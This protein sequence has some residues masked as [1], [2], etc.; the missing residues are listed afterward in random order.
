MRHFGKDKIFKTPY[1]KMRSSYYLENIV[2]L[3]RE[4]DTLGC[5]EFLKRKGLLRERMSCLFCETWM[6][7]VRYARMCDGF[8]WKCMTKSCTH[9]KTTL[10]IRTGSPFRDVRTSLKDLTFLIYLWATETPEKKACAEAGLSRPTVVQAYR[11]LRKICGTY[12]AA[13]P[14]RLGGPGITCQVDES[15]FCY[16]PKYHR[17]RAPEY[18]RW[19]FGVVDTS[20]TPACGYMECVERRDAATLLP[21]IERVCFP[22]TT[23]VSDGWAAYSGVQG[24]GYEHRV[25]NHSLHFVD[26]HT[27]AHTQHIESYWCR[28][29]GKLKAMKGIQRE[30]LDGYLHEFMWRE[31]FGGNAFENIL[32]H[33][34]LCHDNEP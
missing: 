29:K 8:R 23:V 24:L 15:L 6:V 34:K 12:L 21:I 9:Y 26:S 25:V 17:G 13:N 14:I 33:M 3:L 30:Y 32:R 28:S 22:G 19:V 11:F 10:S 2:P 27:G 16:K 1:P 20:Y 18:E 31:R 5:I 4:G 7:W